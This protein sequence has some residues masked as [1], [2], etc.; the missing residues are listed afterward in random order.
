MNGSY[1]SLLNVTV[2]VTRIRSASRKGCIAFGHR[3][4]VESGVNDRST[5]IVIAVP[6]STAPSSTVEVGGI[7]DVYGESTVLHREHSGFKVSEIQVNAQDIRLVRPSGSQ[8]IQWLADNAP[9]VGEVKATK[10]WDAH[11]EALYDILDF[12]N[13]QAIS[14]I[15]PS[16]SVRTDLFSAW[17]ENG[18]AKTLRFVQDKGI[19]LDLARKAI[20]FHKGNTISAL[21][22]DPYRLLSFSGSWAT[23]DG[24]ARE[25]FSVQ[26]DDPRRLRAAMEEALYRIAEKGHTCATI[27]DLHQTVSRLLAPHRAPTTALAK[28]LL[29]GT[30]SGQFIVRE[31]AS[32]D[33]MLHAPGT[34]IM[35]RS[36]AEFIL[37]LLREPDV[38]LPLF[39]TDVTRIIADFERSERDH[40]GLSAFTLN[41]AQRDAVKTSFNNRFSII[42]GGAGVGKTTVLKALYK[43]LDTLGRPRFQ[44]ALSGRAAAR[45]TEATQETAM[46]IAGF[47]RS[48]TDEEMGECPVVVIDEASMLDVVTFYKLTQKLPAGTHLVLVGD[49][50]QLPPIGAG[51]VFHVLC[52]LAAIPVTRLTEVKR[53]AKG[54]EIPVAASAIREGK[55][56]AFSALESA[57]V[58]FIQCE[59]AEIISETMRL[60]EM[61]RGNSQILAATRSSPYAGVELINRLC[62]LRYAAGARQLEVINDESGVLE[63]TGFCEG[64]LLI[65]TANDWSRNLQNGRLGRL[66]TVFDEPVNVNIGTEERPLWRLALARA[67]FEGAQHYLFHSD[68]DLIQHAYAITVHKS[69]GSQFRRVIVPVVKSKVLDRTFAYTALTRAQIQVIFVGDVDAVKEA[70]ALP[71]R[72]FSRQVGLKAM[73]EDALPSLCQAA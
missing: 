59:E 40:L 73:L 7:Y 65:Y 39:Q 22:D 8:L 32:G 45:M 24:V 19:P 25:R 41:D 5:A 46:T 6:A 31:T 53:Q 57:E 47:L 71:P 17:L 28:A 10:L 62:H 30:T 11:Q 23:V 44:M 13:H 66:L 9:G 48:V 14:K 69:Q 43:A 70:V 12:S 38:Q 63:Q 20:K 64:D 55:W 42:T 56:P 26:L 60:Y 50:F 34:Y 27:S 54:S 3:V 15:L 4:D 67:D 16:E 51:L 61:D 58:V 49:P 2:R 21:Q 33:V 37:S 36:C 35:E 52:Q 18:D 72:A 68:V 1:P 29:Q